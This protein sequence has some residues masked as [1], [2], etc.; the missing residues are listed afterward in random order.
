[1]GGSDE[2]DWVVYRFDLM[3]LSM[4]STVVPT[5]V[6]GVARAAMETRVHLWP[7]SMAIHFYQRRKP[8]APACCGQDSQRSTDL[9]LLVLPVVKMAGRFHST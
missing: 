2:L 6:L 8:M 4:T 1:M 9:G 3:Y 7:S 5:S